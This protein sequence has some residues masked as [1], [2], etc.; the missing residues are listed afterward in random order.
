ML[1][2]N[3]YQTKSYLHFDHRIKIEKAESYV[4]NPSRIAKHSFLPL[5]YFTITTDKYTG[6]TNFDLNNKPI[7]RK[8]RK[9]MYAGHLDSYIYKYYAEIL[10]NEFY[11]QHCD[12]IGIDECVIAYRNNKPNKSNIDFAAEV[13]SSIVA[14]KN[15]Y[16]YVGDFTDYFGKIDHAKLKANLSKVM[17]QCYL[18]KDWYNIYK[19]IT[20]YGYYEKDRLSLLLGSD[21]VFKSKGAKSYFNKISHFRKFRKE[22]PP[23]YNKEKIGIPQGT[24]I[25]AVFANVYAVNFDSKMSSIANE[26]NGLYRRYSDDF[27]LVVPKSEVINDNYFKDLCSDIKEYAFNCKIYLNEDKS[28]YLKF[29]N[30]FI[31]N[32][33]NNYTGNLDY[34]GFVF[35]GTRVS[36]RGKSPYKFYRQAKKL[37]SLAQRVKKVKKLEGLPYQKKIYGLYTDLGGKYGK[38]GNFIDYARNAQNKFD[39]ISPNTEN[40]IMNQIKNRKKRIEN[41]LGIKIHSKIEI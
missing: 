19:S 15:C 3:R 40:L 37:I 39:T 22:N 41:L 32:L 36:M 33:G 28:E 10:N 18:E 2:R 23:N 14:Y 27:I 5:L 6:E 29:N 38:Y 1:D 30:N 31:Y 11:N 8:T 16:I 4:T 7:K 9:I 21:S 17:D 26:H 13:I 35:D 24:A 12:N 25:S 34:L 20:K